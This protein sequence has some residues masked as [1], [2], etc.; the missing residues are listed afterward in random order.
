MDTKVY[1][2]ADLTRTVSQITKD[3]T[4]N[5]LPYIISLDIFGLGIIFLHTHPQ[6]IYYNCVKFH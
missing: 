4:H 5:Y 2:I 1:N 3:A 6:V